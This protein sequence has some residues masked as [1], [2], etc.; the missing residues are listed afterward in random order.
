M[1]EGLSR[2]DRLRTKLGST[3]EQSSRTVHWLKKDLIA[4]EAL[5]QSAVEMDVIRGSSTHYFL[6]LIGSK[7]KSLGEQYQHH[8][9]SDGWIFK[10]KCAG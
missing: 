4:P 1:K 3:L 5:I 10:V 9:G 8:A 2:S 6:P 7:R